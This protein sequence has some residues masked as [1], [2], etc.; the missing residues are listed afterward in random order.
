MRRWLVIVLSTVAGL[1]A[2]VVIAVAGGLVWLN[3]NGGRDFVL[4]TAMDAAK[5]SGL[6]LALNGVDG[7]LLGSLTIAEV[8][9]DDQDGRWLDARHLKLA[10]HP[11]ELLRG[12]LHVAELSA[13]SIDLPRA[14]SLPP[15]EAAPSEGGTPSLPVEIALDK[16]AV[17]RIDLGEA[18]AGLAASL[19]LD[20]HAGAARDAGN[21]GLHINRLDAP[22]AIA[23]DA[24][25]DVPQDALALEL[26]VDEPGGGLLSQ[27]LD[28]DGKPP[29]RASLTGDG[30]LSQWRGTLQASI[31][32][33]DW[34][35]LTASV[36]GRETHTITFDGKIGTQP[37]AKMMPEGLAPLIGPDITLAGK[38]VIDPRQ[39]RIETLDIGSEG[40]DLSLSGAYGLDAGDWNATVNLSRLSPALA[41]HFGIAADRPVVA[42]DARSARGRMNAAVHVTADRLETSG[43]A[44][45]GLDTT[46]KAA[47]SSNSAPWEI[48]VTGD[49]QMAAL[50]GEPTP[51]SDQLLGPFSLNGKAKLEASGAAA[52]DDLHLTLGPATLIASGHY[53]DDRADGKLSLDITDLAPFVPGAAA[54]EPMAA[55]LA[56]TMRYGAADGLTLNDLTLDLPG[57]QIAGQVALDAAFEKIEAGIKS[58]GF[59]IAPLGRLFGAPV[60]G[61]LTLDASVT[62]A[63]A[64]PTAKLQV[65]LQNAS[66]QGN[67]LPPAELRADV[68]TAVSAPAG[69]VALTLRPPQGAATLSTRFTM[70]NPNTLNLS[71]IK[72]AGPGV[73]GNGQIR[74]ALDR[75]LASGQFKL[76][77]SNVTPLLAIAGLGGGGSAKIG[78][79]LN[80]ANNQQ[81]ADVTGSIASLVVSQGGEELARIGRANLG[82]KGAL[83]GKTP[84]N[85]KLTAETVTAG[86]AEIRGVA[87]NA[88]GTA[89]QITFGLR[90][91]APAYQDLE[92]ALDGTLSTVGDVRTIRLTKGGGSVRKQPFTL[93]PGMTAVI[94]PESYQ[95]RG[96]KI[97]GRNLGEAAIDGSLKKNAIEAKV[98]GRGISLALL[99]DPAAQDKTLGQIDVTATASGTTER[100]MGQVSLVA[101]DVAMGGDRSGSKSGA[102]ADLAVDDK[103]ANVKISLTNLSSQPLNA[104]ASLARSPKGLGFDENSA[105]TGCL[106]WNGAI[107]E[108]LKFAPLVGQDISGNLASDLT[109]SGTMG[110]PG[111]AGTVTLSD[112][113][114]EDYTTGLVLRFPRLD[115][116]GDTRRLE[117]RPFEA[118]D[119]TG[120][121]IAGR[122]TVTLDSA[123]GFPFNGQLDFSQARVLNR[124]DIVAILSGNVGAEGSLQKAM[125][126]G[127]LQTER[128]EVNLDTGLPP[129]VVTVEV[130]E[131]PADG[132]GGPGQ[133]ATVRNKNKDDGAA[134]AFQLDVKLAMPGRVFVRGRGLDSEWEGNIAVAGSATSPRVTGQLTSRRGQFDLVSK[135]FRVQPSTIDLATKA[136]G[137]VDALLNIKAVNS[138][139]DLEVTVAVTGTGNAPKIELSSNPTLPQDEILSRL[140]FG[141]NRA[142][143]TP[144]E[145]LQL[146]QA[147]QTLSGGGGG[148]NVMAKL[149]G[150]LG[151]DV[152]RVDSG[153]SGATGGNTGPS[154]EA[155]KYITDKVYVGVKQG[156]SQGT[157]AV[158]VDVDVLKNMSVG[159]E[160]RQDGSNRLGVKYKWDY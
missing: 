71:V 62:G 66:A 41:E 5:D 78:L 117:L 101:R 48:A 11:W 75:M 73:Q 61:R 96:F 135:I 131:I 58:A 18:L 92:L 8:T 85:A 121:K 44:I 76:D 134:S 7:Q 14:P 55:R 118:L 32:N 10:W 54:T 42:V 146:A 84:M 88:R 147:L 9:I 53:G 148:L 142:S 63:T 91:S 45:A 3:S 6:S 90:T 34:L 102:R 98:T 141:K 27:L 43:V 132:S 68:T 160:V 116:V 2:L 19:S 47:Q 110:K 39:A 140:L 35:G 126:R 124:D 49:G 13:Q 95:L 26:H 17:G 89:D 16:L 114:V 129:S 50:P 115:I 151:V 120:G 93:Q 69:D 59:D 106:A 145:A 36:E 86:G 138:S 64:D 143:L 77:A 22:G 111:V 136:D 87:L 38:T 1:L 109:L 150:A 122:A 52:L 149:R 20:A 94:A 103:A 12:R 97:S 65:N 158:T 127:N 40:A 67:A 60:A 119:P 24:R 29:I 56:T 25:F 156:A 21:L 83:G 152:L 105:L 104:S 128:V 28:L 125:I 133:Q 100:P 81:Q 51:A 46:V 74:L 15:S 107:A 123:A 153:T 113:K 30:P 72:L 159:S 23:L 70:P 37:F 130:E 33:A 137:G 139:N 80:A 108:I 82:A 31:D 157:S 99:S 4:R 154:L 144:F 155:G 79:S 112:G 57:G